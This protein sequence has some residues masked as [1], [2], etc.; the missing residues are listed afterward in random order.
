MVQTQHSG[1]PEAGALRDCRASTQ[2]QDAGSSAVRELPSIGGRDKD[3]QPDVRGACSR[4]TLDRWHGVGESGLA[5]PRGVAR[6]CSLRHSCFHVVST[7][8]LSRAKRT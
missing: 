8:F 1:L 2:G 3:G 4:G 7:V 6:P 5:A